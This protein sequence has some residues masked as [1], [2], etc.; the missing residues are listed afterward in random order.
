MKKCVVIYVF[1]VLCY[2]IVIELIFSNKKN[3]DV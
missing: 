3:E 2:M 1:F